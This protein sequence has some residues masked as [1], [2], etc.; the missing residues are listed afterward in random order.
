M[1]SDNENLK[2]TIRETTHLNIEESIMNDEDH[3]IE[4]LYSGNMISLKTYMEY[5]NWVWKNISKTKN[6][7]ND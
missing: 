7:A 1:I 5:K 3:L 6:K 4:E 2:Q